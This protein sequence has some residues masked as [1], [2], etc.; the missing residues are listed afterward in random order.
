MAVPSLEV[1]KSNP[2]NKRLG[3]KLAKEYWAEIPFSQYI[4]WVFCNR[5]PTLNCC[6]CKLKLVQK[7]K[8]SK[9]RIFMMSKSDFS[10]SEIKFYLPKVT[11]FRSYN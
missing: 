3:L 9:K 2:T 6:A 4:C 1:T 8:T 11:Q 5:M 10:A 7:R